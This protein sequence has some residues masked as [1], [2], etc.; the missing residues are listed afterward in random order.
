MGKKNHGCVVVIVTT[1]QLPILRVCSI[2]AEAPAL[3]LDL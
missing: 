3:M 1:P 2:C